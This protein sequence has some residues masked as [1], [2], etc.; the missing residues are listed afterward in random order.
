M[1]ARETLRVLMAFMFLKVIFVL[2]IILWSRYAYLLNLR[3]T[4]RRTHTVGSSQEVAIQATSQSFTNLL[5]L[6]N[7]QLSET[8]NSKLELTIE[9]KSKLTIAPEMMFWWQRRNPKRSSKLMKMERQCLILLR[10]HNKELN[11]K[12]TLSMTKLKTA[13][14]KP[15]ATI[16]SIKFSCLSVVLRF[17]WLSSASPS[18]FSLCSNWWNLLVRK[19]TINWFENKTLNILI[20]SHKKAHQDS[21]DDL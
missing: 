3:K 2:P 9:I 19:Q 6:E 5:A 20:S 21:F 12:G 4:W 15:L 7:L 13:N 11:N 14:L 17:S 18:S 16:S 8:S 10:P 1:P